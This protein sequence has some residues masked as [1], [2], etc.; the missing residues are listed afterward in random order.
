MQI[1]TNDVI[2]NYEIDRAGE[3]LEVL[4]DYIL[5]NIPDSSTLF[6]TTIPNLDPNRSDVYSWFGNYRHS[7]DWQTQYTDEQ[8]E[9][10]VAEA[11]ANYNSQVKQLVEAKR[12]GGATIYFADVNS[13]VTDVKTQL[14]DGVHPNNTGYK[15][16]G[17]YWTDILKDYIDN[18]SSTEPP[19][20]V[21]TTTETPVTTTT[22]DNTTTTT[23]VTT[24]ISETTVS[25]TTAVQTTV[26]VTT[27]EP[28]TEVGDKLTVSD[29]VKM[30][31]Y[32]LRDVDGIEYTVDELG[33]YDLD[34]DGR[35]DVYDLIRARKQICG[36]NNAVSE[37]N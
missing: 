11:V 17:A 13:A 16:M 30:S 7:S 35:V 36:E 3:R 15:A 12:A 6:V 24:T 10:A 19:K 32:L 28:I 18:G 4:V 25:T 8:A 22:T 9:Q 1:G 31:L 37:T 27:T 20:P 23:T 14:F 21:V 26:P 29:L 5:A 34:K 33:K 2:D